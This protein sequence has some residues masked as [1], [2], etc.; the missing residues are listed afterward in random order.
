LARVAHGKLACSRYS[1]STIDHHELLVAKRLLLAAGAAPVPI[2]PAA[3]SIADEEEG[4]EENVEEN[5]EKGNNQ[6]DNEV[7]HSVQKA[8]PGVPVYQAFH[9]ATWSQDNKNELVAMF[10]LEDGSYWL[11]LGPRRLRKMLR[12]ETSEGARRCGM[13]RY[14][15]VTVIASIYSEVLLRRVVQDGACASRPR[16][17]S[18][19]LASIRKHLSMLDDAKAHM[20][21]L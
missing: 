4:M 13:C 20:L 9:T 12:S 17:A 21:V 16:L 2:N 1:I 15:H 3:D 10:K 11:K 8:Q 19:N 14:A 7:M 18:E 5:V 6:D